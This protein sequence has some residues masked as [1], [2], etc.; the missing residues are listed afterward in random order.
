M[1]LLR[2]EQGRLDELVEPV[3]AIVEHTPDVPMWRCAL[4]NIYAQLGDRDRAE[5]ELTLLG[6]VSSLPRD[7]FWLMGITTVGSAASSLNDLGLSRCVYE[8]LVPY[9]NTVIVTA[10]V[11]C[12]G[13]TSRPLGMLAT[14]LDHYDEA[15][16][17]FKRALKMNTQIRSRLW[18]AHTQH[19]YAHM[20]LLRNHR[21]DHDKADKLLEQ[22]LATANELGLKVLAD[23]ALLKLGAEANGPRPVCCRPGVAA[24][25]ACQRP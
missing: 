4:A 20:L 1:M 5:R 23:N 18:I 2:R 24:Q 9:T 11:L 3:A 25:S 10:S 14:T 19:D 12:E 7:M 8:L 16:L 21:N 6:D 13:S 17:Y 15:E 22:A